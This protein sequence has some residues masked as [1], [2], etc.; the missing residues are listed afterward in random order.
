MKFFQLFIC[1]IFLLSCNTYKKSQK[2]L[3]I[4]P[5]IEP[6]VMLCNTDPICFYDKHIK[7][8]LKGVGCMLIE[9]KI[10]SGRIDIINQKLDTLMLKYAN[11]KRL[12]YS[13]TNRSTLNKDTLSCY[14]GEKLKTLFKKRGLCVNGNIDELL[15]DRFFLYF[16]FT[17]NPVP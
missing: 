17:V 13:A 11:G 14:Y 5:L 1:I 12:Q 7:D 3:S 16:P 6:N 4:G 10:D 9:F 2:W 15:A 8:T